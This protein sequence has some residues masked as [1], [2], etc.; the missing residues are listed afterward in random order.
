MVAQGRQLGVL[1]WMGTGFSGETGWKDVV[2]G[3][4][5]ARKLLGYRELLSGASDMLGE[6]L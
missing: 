5:K 1:Q 4:L 3:S 2:W 6:P